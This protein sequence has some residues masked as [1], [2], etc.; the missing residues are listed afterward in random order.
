MPGVGS[1]SDQTTGEP[2]ENLFLFSFSTFTKPSSY[3]RLDM[4]TYQLNEFYKPSN[5]FLKSTGLNPDDLIYDLVEFKSKDG[6]MVPLSII[7]K[8]ETLPSL[9]TPPKK[10]ILTHLYAYGGFGNIEKPEFDPRNFAF[11]EK[12]GGIMVIAHIRG[13]GEKGPQ[14][15]EGGAK[16]NRQNHFDDFIGA[17]EYLIQ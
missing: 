13:G 8:K 1:F 9:G 16:F 5:E 17:A 6:T 7:R 14:W 4:E 12:L 3:Y 11:F 10:P 2:D 15:Q